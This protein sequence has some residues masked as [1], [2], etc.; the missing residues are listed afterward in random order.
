MKN[1]GILTS[2]GDAP[3]MNAA[4]HSIVLA[5]TANEIN[6]FGF[7]RG[8][9]GVLDNNYRQLN[10][11]TV[12]H[13]SHLGGTILKTARC[14][15]MLKT[16]YQQIAASNLSALNLD[17][18]IIIGGDGSFRGALAIAS[19]FQAPIIGIP[20]TIDNDIDGCDE[21][22]GFQTAVQTATDAIDKIR[23][24]ADALERIFIVEVM[25]RK[26]GF[27]AL[28]AGTA[29]EAEQII[30]PEMKLTLDNAL[31]LITQDINAY[32][33]H[34]GRN[35]YIIVMAENSIANIKAST[36]AKLVEEKVGIECR[37]IT[38]GHI[39]RG[40]KANSQDRIYATKLGYF[41]V[42][43]LLEG[44][45]NIMVGLQRGALTTIPLCS[46]VEHMKPLDSV[47]QAVLLSHE[48]QPLAY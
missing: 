24:T 26:S 19:Y 44:K 35:S 6:C 13:I 2:G 11:Y 27:I 22:L 40:G 9:N 38:L 43:A 17:G 21:T 5:A 34:M 39:Q 7:E 42:Q 37:E 12:K 46:T 41:A 1:I 8:F 16:E 31:P 10:E 3:G 28:H 14:E 36:L 18:M 25:G 32:V 45:A 20:A 29:C 4:I 23:D 48:Y 15:R 33:K 47:L 30:Y